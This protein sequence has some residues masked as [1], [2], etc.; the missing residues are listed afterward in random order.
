MRS[1]GSESQANHEV[2][3]QDAT[4]YRLKYPGDDVN[5]HIRPTFFESKVC[6]CSLGH[7]SSGALRDDRDGLNSMDAS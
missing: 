2:I 1:E 7:L 3:I 4:V 6:F 5:R